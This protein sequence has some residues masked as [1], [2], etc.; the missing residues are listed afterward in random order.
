MGDD[1]KVNGAIGQREK[2][3]PRN[4]TARSQVPFFRGEVHAKPHRSDLRDSVI[5]DHLGEFLGQE[6]MQFGDGQDRLGQGSHG[7]ILAASEGGVQ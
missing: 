1:G 6:A 5:V 2:R 4:S 3:R 7:A